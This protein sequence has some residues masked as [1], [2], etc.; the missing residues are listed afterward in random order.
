[1]QENH[2]ST[3]QASYLRVFLTHQQK[4]DKQPEK[5]GCLMVW[6]VFSVNIFCAPGVFETETLEAININI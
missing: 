1:M 2:G 3:G 5:F 4:K 6:W